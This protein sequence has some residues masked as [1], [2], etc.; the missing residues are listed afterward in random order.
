MAVGDVRS[1]NLGYIPCLA[2][3]AALMIFIANAISRNVLDSISKFRVAVLDEASIA[4]VAMD[5]RVDYENLAI[6]NIL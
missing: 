3:L 4:P 5:L 6:I 1:S 2:D